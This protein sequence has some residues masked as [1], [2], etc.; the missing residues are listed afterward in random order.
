MALPGVRACLEAQGPLSAAA[1][2]CIA[3]ARAAAPRD[4]VQMGPLDG[5]WLAR[6]VAGMLAWEC[7]FRCVRVV[8]ARHARPT[9]AA[10]TRE[11]RDFSALL[12]PSYTVSTVHAVL[13]CWCVPRAR[14][15]AAPAAARG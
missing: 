1:A 10:A 14:C 6:L 13:M 3:A 15:R 8:A 9:A 2:E 12:V 5:T 4:P 7:A 11:E